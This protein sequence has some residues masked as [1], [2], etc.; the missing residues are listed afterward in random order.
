MLKFA[1]RAVT[2]TAVEMA[3]GV[4]IAP[5]ILNYKVN[6]SLFYSRS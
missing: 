2:V 1:H 6:S 4:I 3:A 5:K